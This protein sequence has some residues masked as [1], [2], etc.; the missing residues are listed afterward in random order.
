MG[1]GLQEPIASHTKGPICQIPH[2]LWSVIRFHPR[3]PQ[4]HGKHYNNHFVMQVK[5][6]RILMP[7]KNIIVVQHI[8]P[9]RYQKLLDGYNV[10]F[11]DCFFK[12]LDAIDTGLYLIDQSRG[13]IKIPSVTYSMDVSSVNNCGWKHQ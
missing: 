1:A 8:D 10:G 5:G 4:L 7:L 13:R 3:N 12:E 6:V 2:P 11:L 9:D